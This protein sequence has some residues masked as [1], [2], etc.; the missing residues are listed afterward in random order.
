[1]TLKHEKQIPSVIFVLMLFVVILY[2][3]PLGIMILNS[4][5]RYDE[6]MKNVLAVPEHF[7]LENFSIVF[8][9]MNYPLTF[10][11]TFIVTLIGTVGIVIFGSMAGY[12]MARVK[13]RY[14]RLTFLYCIVPMMVPFQSFMITLVVIAKNFHLTN[15][16]PGLGIIYWG[17]G[18]PMAL[19][20]Y[21]GF[22]KTIP[23]ELEESA[24]MEGC[25]QPRLFMQIIFPL[26]KSVTASVIVVNAMWIWN[27]FLLPLLVIGGSRE[28]KTLQLAAYTFMGQYK[29][30]WQ[31]IM[32]AAILII[33][34]ALVIY[35]IFQKNIIKGLVAGAVKG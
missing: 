7:S 22:A 21:Q 15:N 33:I 23:Y 31:N 1:M 3:L 13:T 35:L 34:P 25:S 24:V 20:L 10:F 27:D 18:I 9:D 6:I 2:L 17:L 12:K 28:K 32:A 14:S 8:H 16:V 11:N 5:K 19:F 4:V 29:S 26:L 30:E